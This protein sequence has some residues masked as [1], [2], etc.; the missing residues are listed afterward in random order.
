MATRLMN[1]VQVR[2]YAE[3]HEIEEAYNLGARLFRFQI[4]NYENKPDWRMEVDKQTDRFVEL[5]PSLPRDG[6]F[7]LDLH[8]TSGNLPVDSAATRKEVV[9]YW[10]TTVGKLKNYANVHY[11]VLNEPKGSLLNTNLLMGQAYDRIRQTEKNLD[12][13]PKIV[14]VT[15]PAGNPTMLNRIRIF[16]DNKV[17]YECHVYI[18]MKFTH[19]QI[20][21]GEYPNECRLTDALIEKLKA[22]LANVYAFK[23]KA[24][25]KQ[26]YIGEFGC[27]DFALDVDRAKWYRTC[28]QHWQKLRAHSTLHAWREWEHW[29]PSG[30]TL[31]VAK[32]NLK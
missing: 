25:G 5:Y 10:Q 7:I 15:T 6:I 13:A 2:T 17:W 19:Q 21:G 4:F 16:D 24:P 31:E 1:G 9:D 20:P 29:Q 27:V 8:N 28:Y 18:P 12:I 32:N 22:G 3:V 11:G 26:I 14:C 30:K 23:A